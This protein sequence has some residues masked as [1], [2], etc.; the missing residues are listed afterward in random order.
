[1]LGKG[2]KFTHVPFFWSGQYDLKLRYAGHAE[3]W[4]EVI[5]NGDLDARE[6]LA[7]YIKDSKVLAVAGCGRDKEVAA[8]TELMRLDQMPDIETIRNEAIDW[9]SKLSS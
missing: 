4:D 2:I 8:I 3:K 5:I 9:V 1:M 6:F 7:F